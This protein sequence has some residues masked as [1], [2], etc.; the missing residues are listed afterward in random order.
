MRTV[1]LSTSNYFHLGARFGVKSVLAA[2][3]VG[4]ALGASVTTATA[5]VVPGTEDGWGTPP[6]GVTLSVV[7][8][9]GSGNHLL[10]VTWGSIDPIPNDGGYWQCQVDERFTPKSDDK[11]PTSVSKAYFDVKLV[12]PSGGSFQQKVAGVPGERIAMSIR[13]Y[14]VYP[15]AF[16]TT[17]PSPPFGWHFDYQLS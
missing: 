5:D 7:G 9:D 3:L 1:E 11:Y 2:V 10:S 17:P 15:G 6:G 14:T 13:C 12:P 4:S 16:A 8:D